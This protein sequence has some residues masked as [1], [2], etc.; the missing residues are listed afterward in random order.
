MGESQET[1]QLAPHLPALRITMAEPQIQGVKQEDRSLVRNVI[2]LLHACKHP[3]RLCVSWSVANT[4]TGYEVTGLM[5]PNKDYEIFKED[6][7]LIQLADPLRIQSISVRKTGEAP[8][9]LIRVLSRTE[10][11][12]M[13]ELEVLTIQKKRRLL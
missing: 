5:D 4:R 2:Y 9:I 13:T 7:D 10:P 6:L 1:I 11:V 12:M 3:D 8:Q